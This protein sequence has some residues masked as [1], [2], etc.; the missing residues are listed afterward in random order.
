MGGRQ[1]KM[2]S[3]TDARRMLDPTAQS[4]SDEE[5]LRLRDAVREL[6]EIALEARAERLE[7]SRLQKPP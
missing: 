3:L 2:I 4:L 7:L 6:A 1:T 5:V